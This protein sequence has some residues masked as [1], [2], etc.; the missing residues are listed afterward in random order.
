M[1]FKYNTENIS[2]MRRPNGPRVCSEPVMLDIETAN[3]HADDPREL[4]T[5]IVSTQILFNGE[6]YLVRKPEDVVDFFNG[7]YDAFNLNE[8]QRAKTLFICY[9]HNASYDL[10]YLIP[11]FERGI[12]QYG[13]RRNKGIITKEN[14]FISYTVG[15]FEFRCSFR[16]SGMSL[17]KW[18]NEMNIEHK[19]KV[20][21]YDYDKILYQ[22]SELD[23]NE[24]DYDKYDVLAMREC[25]AKQLEYHR[26]D[27]TSVPYTK[28][29]YIRRTLRSACVSDASYRDKYFKASQLDARL[30]DAM[31]D[32]YAGGYTHNNRYHIDEVIETTV[33]HRDFKS[34]Y[35]TQMAVNDFPLGRPQMIYDVDMT[36]DY[37]D[38]PDI[39]DMSPEYSTLT[40]IVIYEARL[41]TP[42]ITMP[43]LAEAKGRGKAK[44]DL[45]D[46]GRY[47]MFQSDDGI[48]FT[49]TNYDLEII[50]EQ[51]EMEYAIGTVWRMKNEPLPDCILSVVNK[52]FK[53]K[54]DKKNVVKDLTEKYG[55]LDPRTVDAQF[56]LQ[57]D[58]ASLNSIYGCCA[59]NPLRDAW[60]FNQNLEF[61]KTATMDDEAIVADALEKYYK[62]KNS[63]LP[64]QVG[65]WITAMA[66][67]ELY[68]YVKAVGYENVLYCDTDSI[69]YIKTDETEAA[70]EA[71]NAE[72]HA[73]APYVVLDNGKREY[74]DVFDSEPD[75]KAFKGLHSKCYGVVTDKGLELTIAGVPA[76]TLIDV[77]DGKPVYKTREE[78]LA[79]DETDPVKALDKL[80]FGVE[81]TVNTGT[82]AIYIGALGNE[83]WREPTVINVDGHEISTAGGCVIRKTE[84][85]VIR[86]FTYSVEYEMDMFAMAT[87]MISV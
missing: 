78:E 56:E 86:D 57:M 51:Y 33:G 50:T 12:K 22:D 54:S 8:N 76:R 46:N 48:Q 71:L 77:V 19:K 3:N 13:K 9:I 17:E 83:T 42:E 37:I 14:Q 64:Y 72:K 63:F 27:M 1:T 73:K 74:Y 29:G 24:Q 85:K 60:T 79:G 69:F 84:K 31:R 70:I 7:L 40:T 45:V 47:I 25:L 58:K 81:F 62:R 35:P 21:L 49:F 2:F 65:V 5:W 44:H 18:S 26:D 36:D 15:S 34:H 4:R 80:T 52:Y 59:T 43:F 66:R 55:K 68:E 39:L 67:Y 16:L 75:C 10:S 82:T 20:G 28:T 38:I 87:G 53:G 30:Y 23:E 6:Y 32:A 61:K 41:R 11:Y